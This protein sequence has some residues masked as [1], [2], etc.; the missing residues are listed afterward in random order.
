MKIRGRNLLCAGLSAACLIVAE[1]A[2]ADA[3]CLTSRRPIEGRLGLMRLPLGNGHAVRGYQINLDNPSCA[4]AVDADGAPIRLD[5]V[6]S[7]QIIP[8]N[9]TGARKLESLLGQTI[10]VAGYLD[11]GTV[12]GHTRDAV[13]ANSWLVAVPA[14][15][16]GNRVVSD[17]GRPDLSQAEDEPAVVLPTPSSLQNPAERPHTD[18]AIA[19]PDGAATP[20]APP[21]G[22]AGQAGIEAKL[23]KF[24]TSYYLTAE[25]IG[26]GVLRGIYAAKV[27][28][29]GK[30]DSIDDVV[31]DK[32]TYYSRWPV[33][34]FTL[35]PG[36]LAI[37][38]MRD[39]G[40]VY[41]L[42]F[43]Y[44]FKVS[45]ADKTNS[46]TG[47]ARLQVDLAEGHG[48]IIKESGKVTSHD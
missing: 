18:I 14:M 41:E 17:D 46:G 20:Y 13:L 27:D 6:L 16:D 1:A 7:V 35:Q 4:D 11:A 3:R 34:S 24:V 44:D 26:P 48:K 47:Y 15:N 36:T 22:D 45:S 40:P 25:N 38:P 42:T 39:L 12:P 9:E 8:S 10:V 2:P 37:R 21:P 28:Y 19:G 43:N 29:F 31:K 33:R 23:V 32:L 30:T 5:E